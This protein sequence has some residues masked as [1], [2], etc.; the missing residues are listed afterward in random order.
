MA[1]MDIATVDKTSL[2]KTHESETV[3]KYEYY[4]GTNNI[5]QITTFTEPK[6]DESEDGEAAQFK[7][8]MPPAPFQ[9]GLHFVPSA[10]PR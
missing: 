8:R 10:V 6:G 3:A 1:I 9:S 7:R 2:Y 5:K 4:P